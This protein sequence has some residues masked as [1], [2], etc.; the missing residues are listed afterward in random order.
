MDFTDAK[1]II[2]AFIDAGCNKEQI[3]S[4]RK[5]IKNQSKLTEILIGQRKRILNQ[6]HEN[7]NK[8]KCIDYLIYN[9]KNKKSES[10]K[11]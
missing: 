8:M 2:N 4:A 9:L 10:E 3:E 11:I 6:I 7:E 1:E 5:N